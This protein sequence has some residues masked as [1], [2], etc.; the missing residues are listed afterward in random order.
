MNAIFTRWRCSSPRYRCD[1]L[2]GAGAEGR[3]E[4]AGGEKGRERERVRGGGGGG[5][6]ARTRKHT[7]VHEERRAQ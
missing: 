2:R 4:R 7:Y 6:G 5:G 3:E 1:R